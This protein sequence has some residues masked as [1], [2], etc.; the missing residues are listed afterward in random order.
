[1]LGPRAY[2]PVAAISSLYFLL[3][4]PGQLVLTVAMRYTAAFV[5]SDEP[6][7]LRGVLKYLL[8]QTRFVSVLAAVLFMVCSPII[9]SFLQIPIPTVLA[10]A[11]AVALLLITFVNRGV[12]QG[13]LRLNAL[14]ALL[15]LDAAAKVI[16]GVV[17]VIVGL[18]ATGAVLAMGIGL[19]TSYAASVP[20]LRGA[21]SGP[22]DKFDT[23]HLFRFA[24]PVAATVL[25]ITALYSVDVLLVK[26]FFDPLRSGI[27]GSVSTL[28]KM[29]LMATASI[30]GAMF[31]RV[32]SLESRG[33]SGS[34]ILIASAGAI[35]LIAA[36]I[37]LMFALA[38]NLVLLPFGPQ[39]EAAGPY[40][41]AF[42]MAMGL[43]AIANLLANY[44]LATRDDRF[45]VVLT[46]A[47]IGEV[48]A[49]WAFHADLWEVIWCILGLG[50]L[51]VL[52]LSILC[53]T[54]RRPALIGR[55]QVRMEGIE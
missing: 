1:M 29:V 49:I 46:A 36:V 32:T 47:A 44:L 25:G 21:L 48:V 12:I 2:A 17:L 37:V 45:I 11:P 53:L 42:G 23:R 41:P 16:S 27:Y 51:V 31:P 22:V 33:D 5:A 30:T 26:H 18:G 40:L 6:A 10:L 54:G 4:V 43:F 35:V 50:A 20:Q 55:E 39:F 19:A 14:S 9:A 52:A 3:L 8:R 13:E 28:G 24:G 7:R 15:I 34:K 38:P